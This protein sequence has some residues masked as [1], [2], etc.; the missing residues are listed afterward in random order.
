MRTT[1]REAWSRLAGVGAHASAP[2]RAL[3]AGLVAL[4]GAWWLAR[5]FALPDDDVAGPASGAAGR[6]LALRRVLER[7][8]EERIE[9][10]LGAVVGRDHV[11]ARVAVTLDPAQIER[12]ERSYD[13]EHAALV[14]ERVTREGGAV[15]GGEPARAER[16]DTRQRFAVSRVD[17]RT[18]VAPG[19]VQ[20][21][22]AAV[23]VDGPPTTPGGAR[24]A[25]ARPGEELERLR[26]LAK[27]AIGFSE[28]RGDRLEIVSAPLQGTLL[29]HR[30]AASAGRW[31]AAL[32]PRLL[33]LALLGVGL[34]LVLRPARAGSPRAPANPPAPGGDVAEGVA[35]LTRENVA[36]VGEDPE[37]A[38]ELVRGWLREGAP[39]VERR[40]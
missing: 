3:A 31:L 14:E 39:A 21:V 20:R 40:G 7:D 11:L 16:R 30:L 2:W 8:A 13:P 22:S 6:A 18:R 35:R 32:V 1:L 12:T 28:A 26:E 27:N 4:G 29:A 37:R 24:A 10:L 17:S 25:A 36:L 15:R 5:P 23:L 34:A 19:A 38:A 33:G 9:G